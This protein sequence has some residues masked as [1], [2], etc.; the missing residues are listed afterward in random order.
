MAFLFI[1]EAKECCILSGNIVA[2]YEIIVSLYKNHKDAE[3]RYRI[4][5]QQSLPSELSPHPP[6]AT[7]DWL[8]GDPLTLVQ[9]RLSGVSTGNRGSKRIVNLCWVLVLRTGAGMLFVY[10]TY[11]EI[12]TVWGRKWEQN[13]KLLGRKFQN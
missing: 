6:A 2:P 4:G 12:G 5:K 11:T 7:A 13:L 9:T 10:H 1:R 8:C 3:K